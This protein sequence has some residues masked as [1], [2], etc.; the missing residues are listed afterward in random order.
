MRF[1]TP[2]TVSNIFLTVIG[3]VMWAPAIVVVMSGGQIRPMGAMLFVVYWFVAVP[4]ALAA[5]VKTGLSNQD[6]ARSTVMVEGSTLVV[7][8]LCTLGPLLV[9]PLFGYPFGK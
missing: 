9:L 4:F 6:G 5:M 8:L 1:F 7:A 3:M 2:I